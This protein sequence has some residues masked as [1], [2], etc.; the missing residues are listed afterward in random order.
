LVDLGIAGKVRPVVV[1]SVAYL[2]DERALV[3]YV[4]RT[5]AQRQTRFEVFHNASGFDA[6]A[7][8]AQGIGTTPSVKFMRRIATLDAATLVK[9]EA[10]VRR[11]LG[12]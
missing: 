7:F 8:D 11:W 10:A 3:T 6:G 9:V 2:E 1:L 4:P 5:T 12:L